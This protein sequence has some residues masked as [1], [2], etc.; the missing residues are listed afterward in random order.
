MFRAGLE[1]IP[2]GTVERQ[3]LS[4]IISTAVLAAEMKSISGPRRKER[5]FETC[6]LEDLS[7]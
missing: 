1:S 7:H 5:I 2:L 6:G 3:P 4:T